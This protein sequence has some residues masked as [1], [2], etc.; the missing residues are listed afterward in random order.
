MDDVLR[1]AG[2][3]GRPAE[4]HD[5]HGE[6][7]IMV[8]LRPGEALRAWE[9]ARDGLRGRHYPVLVRD[10]SEFEF[11]G[12]RVQSPPGEVL[13]RAGALDVD[14]RMDELFLR[15]ALFWGGVD[16]RMGADDG[17]YFLDAY[18]VMS[19]GEPELLAILPRPEPWAAFAYLPGCM[20]QDS[21]QAEL[22]VAAARRWHDRYGAEPTV[23]DLATGFRVA[24]PPADR[25]A[26]ERLAVEHEM[27]AGLTAG[28]T[29]R[30]YATALMRL[31]GWCLYNRP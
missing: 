18:D 7:I 21:P 24:R 2:L 3:E 31:S 30:N 20:N 8:P 27:L 9:T 23:V 10:G 4:R 15:D 19:Y 12:A 17:G 14:A 1:A 16:E 6:Q 11:P 22:M 26:A 5:H 28:A 29:L 25:A 13:A